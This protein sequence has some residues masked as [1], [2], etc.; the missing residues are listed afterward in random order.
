M[1]PTATTADGGWTIYR[2]SVHERKSLAYGK[3]PDDWFNDLATSFSWHLDTGVGTE[4]KNFFADRRPNRKRVRILEDLLDSV[5]Q[6][7]RIPEPESSR[8]QK[9]GEQTFVSGVALD[10]A[11]IVVLRW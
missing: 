10:N 2:S 5:I 3:P 8:E 4:E 11:D 9:V 6:L 1:D 7:V